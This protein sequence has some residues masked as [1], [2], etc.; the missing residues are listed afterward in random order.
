LQGDAVAAADLYSRVAAGWRELG[1]DFDLALSQ[2]EF[3]NVVGPSH[4]DAKTA[5]EEAREIFV[6]LGAVPFLD[7]SLIQPAPLGGSNSAASG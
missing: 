2:W 1:C 4:L 7:G 6:R 5:G 3:A